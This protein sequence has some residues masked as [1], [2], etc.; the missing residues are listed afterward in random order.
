MSRAGVERQLGEVGRRL[1]KARAELVVH[2]EQLAALREEADDTSVRALVTDHRADERRHLEARRAAE[3]MARSREAVVADIAR[4]V[5]AR[6]E[7]L[8]QLPL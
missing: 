6:D 7:L 3:A 1:A 8:E 2:D 5:Q 4:L